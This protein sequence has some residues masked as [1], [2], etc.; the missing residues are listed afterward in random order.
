MNKM[1]RVYHFKGSPKEIGFAMGRV[2]GARLEQNIRG[3]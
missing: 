1:D 3:S 2:L